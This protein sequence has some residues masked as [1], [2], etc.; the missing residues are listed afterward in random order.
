MAVKKKKSAANQKRPTRA[1]PRCGLCGKRGKLTKTECCGN[2]ICDD[3][4]SYVLFSY[5]RNSCS[6][7]HRRHTLC[8]YHHDEGHAG[9]WKDCKKCRGAFKTEMYVWYGT[10]EYN[11]EKLPDPPDYEQ[12]RCTDCG[13][14]IVLSEGGYSVLGDDH[15]CY[16]CAAKRIGK[17]R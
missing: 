6:R 16:R 11:F 4:D 17:G 9:D 15:W 14:V 13:A 10:N 12:T 1:A 7:N 2:W 8:A 5:A 3:E